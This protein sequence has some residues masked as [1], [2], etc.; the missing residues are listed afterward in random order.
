MKGIYA[1]DKG[2]FGV[3][4]GDQNLFDQTNLFYGSPRYGGGEGRMQLGNNFGININSDTGFIINGLDRSEHNTIAPMFGME[5]LSSRLQLNTSSYIQDYF[6]AFSG[7]SFGPQIDI[8]G[9]RILPI[10][11][12][13]PGY[14]TIGHT[15][16]MPKVYPTYGYGVHG[17]FDKFKISYGEVK[18]NSFNLQ[19]LRY[20]TTD[21]SAMYRFGKDTD[22]GLQYDY[23]NGIVRSNSY[24]ILLRFDITP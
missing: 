14:G 22:L 5:P 1:D 24:T 17:V 12:A 15:G 13:G 23:T 18:Y 4:I 10:I 11:K 21:G 8:N 16:F 20:N 19:H 9:Y 7:L 6:Q 3:V 2:K